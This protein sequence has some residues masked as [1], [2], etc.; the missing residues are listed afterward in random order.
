MKKEEEKSQRLI[1]VFIIFVALLQ[2][3]L[4]SIFNRQAEILGWPMLFMYIMCTWL[5]LIFVLY[6]LIE[7]GPS[8]LK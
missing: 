6:L 3:P 1:A 5:L 4:V 7:K 8:R 2:F